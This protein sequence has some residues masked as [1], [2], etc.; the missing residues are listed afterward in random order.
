VEPLVLIIG[1]DE[2][3]HLRAVALALSEVRVE[4]IHFD[5]SDDE[6]APVFSQAGD[7]LGELV[8]PGGRTLAMERVSSVF[9]RYAIDSLRPSPDLPDMQKYGVF[10]RI[11]GLL[12]PLRFIDTTR[13]INDPWMEA[14]ADCKI[15]QRGLATLLGM[16]VPR[17]IISNDVGAIESFFDGAASIVKSLS[18]A[19]IG[20]TAN[21]VYCDR[22]I[23]TADFVAP[24]TATF[25]SSV[26]RMAESDGTPLLVQEKITKIADLRC[27]VI[28]ENVHAFAIPYR[29]GEPIDFRAA[30]VERV[31][32][33]KL[34]EATQRGL[35]ALNRRLNVRYSACDLLLSPQGEE[36][37]LEANVAG[38]WLFCDIANDM[39]VTRDIVRKLVC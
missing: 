28:D 37:F 9:C 7:C 3:I 11:Q 6:G 23:P 4:H 30:A 34:D 36:I 15:L 33:Y 21:E 12:A 25:D 26:A 2:D 18:D 10:E 27:M 16:K 24:Y 14:R 19:S 8:W 31:E 22:P 39:K 32:P 13:W 20:V 38:N 17:Q 1:L 5:P 35:V 29:D